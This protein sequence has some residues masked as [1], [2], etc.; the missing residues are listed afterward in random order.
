MRIA[1]ILVILLLSM[2]FSVTIF[3]Q[4]ACPE[5]V[6][7]A[8][9][10]INDNCADLDRN[11]A[12]YGFNRVNATF[13]DSFPE[14]FFSNPSDRVALQDLASL[15]TAPLDEENG[16]WGVAL[17]SVQADIPNTLP[18]Q[19]VLFL[20]MGDVK[21]ENAVDS[22]TAFIPADPIA[23]TTAV[24]ASNIRI[25]PNTNAFVLGSVP[26]GT[27]FETDAR[28]SDGEWFRIIYEGSPAW[29]NRVL[30]QAADGLSEL[31]VIQAENRTPMQAFYFSTGA[32]TSACNEA[33]DT[34]VIQGPE[35]IEVNINANGTDIEIGSTIALRTPEEGSMQ[36]MSVSGSAVVDGV[37]IPGGFTIFAQTD[38]SG[39]T[40]P[41]SLTGFRP[42]SSDELQQLGTV[43]Q[44]DGE[45]MNYQVTLPTQA[46]IFRIRQAVANREEVARKCREEGL[47]LAECRQILGEDNE[48]NLAL[49][50]QRCL[51]AG[52][53]DEVCRRV[54]SGNL[55]PTIVFRCLAAGYTSAEACREAYAEQSS[56]TTLQE[57]CLAAGAT[58]VEE[59]RALCE[60][61][62]YTTFEECRAAVEAGSTGDD[63]TSS[64]SS[65]VEFC[66]TIGATTATECQEICE[67]HG[68]PVL[69]ECQAA[70]YEATSS[71]GGG[72]SSGGGGTSSDSGPTLQ[73][74]CIANGATTAK[75]CAAWCASQGYT[76]IEDCRAGVTGG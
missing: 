11:S 75:Q 7:T 63:S 6:E 66:K 68:Y 52:Y 23:L 18:G 21:I 44:I 43:E 32:G 36:I 19:S 76:T 54:I 65:I 8:L 50:Y 46:E 28:S 72:T 70:Y 24:S 1:K 71:G 29:I 4:D 38:E 62:G 13:F 2:L 16:I 5:V 74:V 64:G 49:R 10:A 3:A 59:C 31:P 22:E 30:I 48:D 12:C 47:S 69:E 58:T 14:G 67:A 27:I 35:D 9:N 42:M 15:Q 56:G 51:E 57:V 41:G 45:F 17:M 25:E 20:L 61:R 60:A 39:T 40:I 73:E 37:P 55:N 34:L 53:S 26:S 33:P